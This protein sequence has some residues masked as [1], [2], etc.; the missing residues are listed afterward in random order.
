METL[1]PLVFREHAPYILRI[2]L[3]KKDRKDMFI[4][5]AYAQAE[6]LVAD[7]MT[8]TPVDAPSAGEAFMM[9]MGLIAVLVLLFYVLMIRP[10]QKR[11]KEHGSML[12]TLEK[13]TKIVTQ[14]GLV[15]TVEKIMDTHKMSIKVEGT[16]LV[17]LRSAIMSTYDEAVPQKSSVAN[18]D[19]PK[20]KKKTKK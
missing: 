6:E 14:G 13:G 2:V 11:M 19:A 12:S 16:T 17:I 1:S 5:K 4:S 10:Q 20:N 3:Y 9:N 18:D 8:E 7:V 15:G